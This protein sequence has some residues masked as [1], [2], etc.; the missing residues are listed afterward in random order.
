MSWQ[1]ALIDRFIRLLIR[2]RDWGDTDHAVAKRAR[3][4]FG[5]PELFARMHTRR[6]R[7]DR[8]TVDGVRGEWLLPAKPGDGV[9]FYIH[10]GGYVSCSPAS[11][12]PIT[13][14]LARLANKRV[15]SLQYRLAPEHRFPAAREDAVRAYEWLL[16]KHDARQIAVAGDSAGGGLS[17]LLLIHARDRGLPLPACCALLSPWTDLS[18]SNPSIQE[19][20]GQCAMFRPENTAQFAH[21]FL[22]DTDPRDPAV[23]PLFGDLRNLPPLLIQVGATELLLDDSRGLH[24]RAQAAGT[25]STLHIFGDV[26]HDWHMLDGVIPEARI[27]LTEIAEFIGY[28]IR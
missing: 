5:S 7:V 17:L 11:H 1:S 2:R 3:R 6:L 10:G 21:A 20:D 13:A 15:F 23:S 12:R 26:F 4:L 9:I 24:E 19:N 16:S 14:G 22:G 18:G 8:V 27:A 25:S 28:H